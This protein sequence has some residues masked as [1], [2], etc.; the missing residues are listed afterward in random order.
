VSCS[1][2]E[3]TV[4]ANVGGPEKSEGVPKHVSYEGRHAIHESQGDKESPKVCTRLKSC[5]PL[6]TCA[7]APFYRETNGLLHFENTL[8]SKEYS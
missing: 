6:Y 2:A 1:L 5:E 7:R 3:P 4:G 8:G